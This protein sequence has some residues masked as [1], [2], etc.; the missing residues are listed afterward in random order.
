MH[1]GSSIHE[2]ASYSFL[3]AAYDY[4]GVGSLF[5]DCTNF[6]RIY[7]SIRHY[8]IGAYTVYTNSNSIIDSNK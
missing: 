8:K 1:K 4:E 7:K 3:T 6:M 5:V 2:N